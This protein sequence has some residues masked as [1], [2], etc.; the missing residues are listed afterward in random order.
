MFNYV[1]QQQNV[2]LFT[3]LLRKDDD[4]CSAQGLWHF[5]WAPAMLE[6]CPC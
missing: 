4:A 2:F 5:I 6:Y 3:A 1:L